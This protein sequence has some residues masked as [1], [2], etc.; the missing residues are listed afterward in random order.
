[1]RSKS[2]HDL[3]IR[4]VVDTN[5][6]FNFEVVV[7]SSVLNKWPIEVITVEC[8]EDEG[9]RLSDVFEELD[10]QRLFIRLVEYLE[11]SN[12]VFRLW[13]IFEVLHIGTDYLPVRDQEPFAV[14]DV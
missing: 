7:F 9:A 1:M 8:H 10:Q 11:L 5:L 14:Y 2:S 6:L 4:E 3:A 13:R 12:V